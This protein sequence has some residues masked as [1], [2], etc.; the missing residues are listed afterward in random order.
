MRK[1]FT[2]LVLL[3]I[4]PLG[5]RGQDVE[6]YGLWG[7]N[8]VQGFNGEGSE[9]SPYEVSTAA[10]L[11]YLAQQVNG[12]ETYSGKYFILTNDIVLNDKVLDENGDL[13]DDVSGLKE[14]TPIGITESGFCGFFDGRNFSIKG[15]Y[16]NKTD[17]KDNAKALF[18][19]IGRNGVVENFGVIDSYIRANTLCA[20][21]A[22]LNN[23]EIINCHT[24]GKYSASRALPAGIASYNYGSILR[25]YNE[26]TV[27][28]EGNGSSDTGETGGI[29]AYNHGQI[30][31]C[32]NKGKISSYEGIG[33]IVGINVNPGCII[34]CF[35]IGEI[36]LRNAD[37]NVSYSGVGEISCASNGIINNCFWESGNS[38]V[39]I[40]QGSLEN[41]LKKSKEEFANEVIQLLNKGQDKVYWELG[42]DGYPSLCN[43]PKDI[44]EI[45][46]LNLVDPNNYE[47]IYDEET[48]CWYY[49]SGSTSKQQ[50][51]GVITG[52]TSGNIVVNI[53]KNNSLKFNIDEGEDLG[54]LEV[55][56]NASLTVDGDLDIYEVEGNILAGENTT[57]SGDIRLDIGNTQQFNGSY[58]VSAFGKEITDITSLPIG[59]VLTIKVFPKEESTINSVKIGDTVVDVNGNGE[60]IYVIKKDDSD[61]QIEVTFNSITPP[62]VVT[63]HDLHITE[64]AGAKLVSRYD[65]KRTPD[66]GSFTLSLEK[67]EGYE[68]CEPTVYY[69]RGRFGEWKELKLDEVSG[70]YQIR[71]VYTDIY[72][73]VSGDGI[74]PVSNEEVE[75]Q[76]VKVYTQNG[77]I[78]VSTPSLMDVQIISMTG[79]VVAADKVAGQREFRNI[80]EGI[81]VVRVGEEIVKVR[82]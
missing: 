74:W 78:I 41:S 77:A 64:S 14:W 53:N 15:V 35:N 49:S 51:T 11:A 24:K 4:L 75:A 34:N 65:K 32:Y 60:Y 44:V 7:E 30:K 21:I 31:N 37:Y 69:K 66:G 42:S 19:I 52:H 55:Q 13:V 50:F 68:D 1:I 12:G 63:Y 47:I 33:G 72:V 10:E 5:L 73:K 36:E 6:G 27:V 28:V 54:K 62:V 59:T 43:P 8:E 25:C 67:E 81:Y 48:S 58:I 46:D 57:I 79:S 40:N 16:I 61:L 56:G 18:C 76:E 3:A 9:N 22:Y 20:G 80:A 82:L 2:L 70:Y 26:G 45:T 71:S 17:V 39:Y 23:G 38:A 29:C